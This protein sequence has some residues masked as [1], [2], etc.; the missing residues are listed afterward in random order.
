MAWI[1]FWPKTGASTTSSRGIPSWTLDDIL[2]APHE[3]TGVFEPYRNA[4][5]IDVE[6]FLR[7]VHGAGIVQAFDNALTLGGVTMAAPYESLRHEGELDIARIRAGEPKYIVQGAFKLVYDT[8]RA[9]PKVAFARPTDVWFSDWS[10]PVPRPEFRSD[11]TER[12]ADIS[13]EGRWLTWC[14]SQFCGYLDGQVR[15]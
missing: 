3:V 10:G 4:T 15:G 12:L 2:A 8:D 7:E 11:V 9:L 13:G 14:L 1:G 5:G 6:A